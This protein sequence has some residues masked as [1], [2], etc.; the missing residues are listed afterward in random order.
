MALGPVETFMRLAS[1]FVI[2]YL[3]GSLPNNLYAAT[4]QSDSVE[5]FNYVFRITGGTATMK[6]MY[7]AAYAGNAASLEIAKIVLSRFDIEEFSERNASLIE[8]NISRSEAAECVRFIHS[9]AGATLLTALQ[10]AEDDQATERALQAVPAKHRAEIMTF[11]SLPCRQKA[12][13]LFLSEEMQKA[14]SEYGIFL[15]CQ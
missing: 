1:I 3:A 4:P 10:S 5:T 12:A 14:Q 2:F 13:D 15:V 9:D 11:F 8:W 7:E 6:K